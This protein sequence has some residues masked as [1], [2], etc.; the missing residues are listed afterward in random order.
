MS[1]L[2]D[3]QEEVVQLAK[4]EI[5]DRPWYTGVCLDQLLKM[6]DEDIQKMGA[7]RAVGI[8]VLDTM[9]WDAPNEGWARSTTTPLPRSTRSAR[10]SARASTGRSDGRL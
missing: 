5:Q 7:Q 2:T 10:P 3:L 1:E 9:Y 4:L 8:V 6:T